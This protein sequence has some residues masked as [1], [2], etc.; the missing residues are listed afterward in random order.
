V[1]GARGVFALA[2]GG[3]AFATL[4]E[5][6]AEQLETGGTRSREFH[7]VGD[8]VDAATLE[9][10]RLVQGIV[11]RGD[12][13]GSFAL[14]VSA[15]VREMGLAE[16]N[17]ELERSGYSTIGTHSLFGIGMAWFARSAFFGLMIEGGPDAIR[18][19]DGIEGH[20][21]YFDLQ[22]QGG[23]VFAV[24]PSAIVY[25]YLGFGFGVVNVFAQTTDTART[26]ILSDRIPSLPKGFNVNS[27][28]PIVELGLGTFLSLPFSSTPAERHGLALGTEVGYSFSF[29]ES[30]WRDGTAGKEPPSYPGPNSGVHGGTLRVLLRYVYDGFDVGTEERPMSWCS[31]RGCRVECDAGY[32]DCDAD[33]RN[34]CETEMGTMDNCGACGDACTVRHGV[35]VCAESKQRFDWLV[36]ERGSG[37]R[38]SARECAVAACA[39]G[40]M[41]CNGRASDG[42]EAPTM[43]DKY[44]CGSCGHLCTPLDHCV[45]GTCVP[46]DDAYDRR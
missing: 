24:R 33:P 15:A 10:A 43:V 3:T 28:M 44:N 7:L 8:R 16:L 37:P 42:C 25:P 11:T 6:S 34:G 32:S 18:S 13:A 30:E 21:G 41:N 2:V 22:F 5:S 26:P 38:S 27:A 45:A 9:H 19:A 46:K 29:A 1:S 40:F 35:G 4:A 39:P 31:G 17:H 12:R 36:E 14:G 23:P 20:V